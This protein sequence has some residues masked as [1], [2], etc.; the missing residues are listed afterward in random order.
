MAAARRKA[1]GRE[2]VGEP[3]VYGTLRSP[4]GRLWVAASGR[5]LV[6]LSF[7]PQPAGR[8]AEGLAGRV[9]VVFVRGGHGLAEYETAL[10]AFLDGRT[11]RLSLPVDLRGVGEFAVRVYE[12]T[13]AIPWGETRS[14]AE[15]AEAVASR[16]H[17]RAVGQALADNPVP[18]VIPCHRVVASRGGLGG[19][20]AGLVWKRRLL[21]LERGQQVLEM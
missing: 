4:W 20:S 13:R 8:L 3:V 10:V 7:R 5:G 11:T 12:A 2:P 15:V 17:A 9:P 14:Y 16:R 18:I 1:A 6:A 21:A 19:F